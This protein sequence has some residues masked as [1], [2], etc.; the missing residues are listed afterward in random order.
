MTSKCEFML[1][2]CTFIMIF[3][4]SGCRFGSGN[5]N[6]ASCGA[7]NLYGEYVRYEFSKVFNLHLYEGGKFEYYEIHL[8]SNEQ[9][10]ISGKWNVI[11]DVLRLITQ[12]QAGGK[13]EFEEFQISKAGQQIWLTPLEFVEFD[14]HDRVRQLSYEKVPEAK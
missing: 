14:N 12:T 11:D 3:V 13:E 9:Y 4:A 2:A 6:E 10:V 8:N 7:A 5:S 1:R